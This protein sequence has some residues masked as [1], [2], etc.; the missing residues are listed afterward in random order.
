MKK[1][2]K[3]SSLSIKKATIAELNNK[4]VDAVKGGSTISTSV[5]AALCNT[6]NPLDCS[7]SAFCAY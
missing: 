6:I 2:I 7:M 5:L 1:Q 4:Q 3:K